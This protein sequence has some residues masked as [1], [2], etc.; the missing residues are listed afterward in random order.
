VTVLTAAASPGLLAQTPRTWL[1]Q[2][3]ATGRSA[4][5]SAVLGQLV[6]QRLDDF[7]LLCY[8]LLQRQYNRYEGF[9]IQFCK[10]IT[11]KLK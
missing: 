2:A 6:A 7:R 4:A 3:V 11:I 8:S 5:V 9:S 1:L 10:W